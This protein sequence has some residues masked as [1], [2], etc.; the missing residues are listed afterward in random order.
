MKALSCSNGISCTSCPLSEGSSEAPSLRS[1]D[2]TPPLDPCGVPGD[3]TRH[4]VYTQIINRVRKKA[5][6]AINC[7]CGF[8]GRVETIEIGLGIAGF[9]IVDA[10]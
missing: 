2:C 7:G 4:V 1:R 8:R 10:L 9:D 5:L 6:A 3:T